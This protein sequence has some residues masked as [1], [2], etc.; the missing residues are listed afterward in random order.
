MESSHR[1]QSR[2]AAPDVRK[3]GRER[4]VRRGVSPNSNQSPTGPIPEPMFPVRPFSQDI[5]IASVVL[6]E[7]MSKECKRMNLD[8]TSHLYKDHS[9]WIKYLNVR[10]KTIK[11]LG[12]NIAFNL[13]DLRF[14]S[15]FLEMTPKA[16][17]KKEKT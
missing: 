10:A 3:L 11:L 14:G 1:H 15:G 6:G 9:K 16:R 4:R 7:P 13:H 2:V 5:T 8:S 12:T 17:A